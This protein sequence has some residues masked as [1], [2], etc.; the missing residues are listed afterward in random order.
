MGNL[1]EGVT[2]I[3]FNGQLLKIKLNWGLKSVMG[4]VVF[5]WDEK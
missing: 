2:F 5:L 3:F 4:I 1:V